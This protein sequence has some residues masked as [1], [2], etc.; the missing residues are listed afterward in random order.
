M[1]HIHITM[2]MVM[3]LRTSIAMTTVQRAGMRIRTST[4][5][6][7]GEQY[8]GNAPARGLN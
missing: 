5:N 6:N 7:S 3:T 8:C 4:P 2:Y 1:R